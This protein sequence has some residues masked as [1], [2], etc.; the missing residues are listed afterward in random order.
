MMTKIMEKVS[1][2]RKFPKSQEK[3]KTENAKNKDQFKY[4][5]LEKIQKYKN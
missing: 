1:N 5:N 2:S 3:G 4:G